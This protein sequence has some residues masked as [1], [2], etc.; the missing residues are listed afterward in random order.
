VD[1]IIDLLPSKYEDKTTFEVKDF[2]NGV[3]FKK[4]L[5]S[6]IDTVAKPLLEI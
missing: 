2:S 4:E 5:Q 6:Y 3:E 1:E